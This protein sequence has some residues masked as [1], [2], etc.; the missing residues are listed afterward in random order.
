MKLSLIQM[1]VSEKKC[2]N[3]NHARTLLQEAA[4]MGADVVVLPEMF[5]C[6]YENPSFISNSEPIGS[7]VWMAMS[8]AAREHGIYL[9]AGSMPEKE[10][11]RIYNTSFVF[12]PDGKQ[13]ARHRKIHLFDIDVPGGQYFRESDVF[14]AGNEI[15]TFDT[16]WG[17]IG[18]C[19][20]FDMRFPELARGM[21]RRGAFLIVAPAAFNMTTGPA[22]W[23]TTFRQRAV[24]NQVFTAGTAP[25]RD[26]NGNYISYGNSLICH[27][28]GNIL[29]RCEESESILTVDID[30]EECKKIR[31]QLPLISSLRNDLY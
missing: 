5:C 4:R 30:P 16:P 29:G 1:N 15:T 7:T 28:W 26:I 10:N 17:K 2:D 11:E 3:I 23:E 19:I 25:A 31:M 18:L 20:C 21:M 27:P 22:H 14:S 24:D 6:P 9:I 13:I 8:E 12:D